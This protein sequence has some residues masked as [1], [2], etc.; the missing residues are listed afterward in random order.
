MAKHWLTYYVVPGLIIHLHS[1]TIKD[2]Y[3][4]NKHAS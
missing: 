4:Y 1:S 2:L 3:I